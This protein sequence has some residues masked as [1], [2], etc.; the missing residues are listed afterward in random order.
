MMEL[1]WAGAS[2]YARKCMIV[3]EELGITGQIKT[4]D[5]SGLPTKPNPTTK[6]H[7]PL[8]K[9]PCLVPAD[10]P[11]IYDSRVICQYLCSLVPDQKLIPA[12]KSRFRALTLESLGD[13]ICDAAI[14]IR[15]ETVLRPEEKRWDDWL[16]GQW[17][18]VDRAL[19]AA[20]ENWAA[21][22]AG[23]F[24]LGHASLGA[25][26]GYLDFR[27]G[28]KDWRSGHPKLAKWHADVFS[29]RDS[30]QATMPQG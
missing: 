7:N 14:L 27:Y 22:L 5:G 23:P 10:S 11:A 24:D 21:H 8:G 15:Y 13:G 28:D 9:L 20:E 12:G 3:A 30:A 16:E 19:D 17:G 26:L 2:P 18:K 25:A 1:I 4:V 29:K 6:A